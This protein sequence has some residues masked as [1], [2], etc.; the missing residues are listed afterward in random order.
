[1]TVISDLSV[2]L[3]IDMRRRDQHTKLSVTQA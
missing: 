1:M 3:G 2:R